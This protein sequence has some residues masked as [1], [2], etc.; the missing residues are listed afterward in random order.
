MTVRRAAA[1]IAFGLLLIVLIA[2]AIRNIEL[3]TGQYLSN[4]VPPLPAL[5]VLLLLSALRPFLRRHAPRLAPNRAQ[6]LLL[7]SMLT[8]SVILSGLYHV[9]AF[10]PQLV[11]LQYTGRENPRYAEY[12]RTLPAWYAPQDAQA[13]KDYFEGAKGGHIPWRVWLGPLSCWSLFFLALFVG[14]FSLVTLVQRQWIHHEKLSFPLLTIPLA[15]TTENPLAEG[16]VRLRRWL[17]AL[18]FGVAALFNGINILHIF[19]PSVPAPGFALSFNGLFPN[20]P[21]TPLEQLRL[22]FM[23]ETIGI[24]Y[25]IPLE[26]SFSAWFFYLVVNR[27]IAIAGTAAGYDLPGFPFMREASA[28]GYVAAGLLLLWGLR[29]HFRL[30]S[31][32]SKIENPWAWAGL[33]GSSLFILGFCRAAGLALPLALAYF[34]VIALFVLVYARIRAET[35]VPFG[36]IYP[37]GLPKEMLLNGLSVP[38]ALQWGGV[39]SFV[40]LNSLNW[41]SYFHHPMEQVAYQLDSAKLAE[42]GRIAR[43]ILFTALLLAFI[44]GL[45]AAFWAHLS[46]CC[47]QGSNLTPS[48]GG[49]GE[50]RAQMAHQSNQQMASRL[51]SPP[52]RDY[53]RLLATT[54]GFGFVV[55][56]TALRQRFVGFPFH[57][58]GFLMATAYGDSATGWFPLLVAWLVKFCLLRYG[59]MRMYRAGMPFFLGLAIGH[60]LVAG[61]LWP[62]ISLFI[63]SEAANAY[64][65]V[66]GE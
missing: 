2:V 14:V 65:L 33:F 47:A 29:R 57:P 11:D 59:G 31:G 63:A 27:G 5:A 50:Y 53:P 54:G 7:Y 6:I 60:F 56:L 39:Q 34:G 44:V 36:F 66:F 3:V 52:P 40:L 45:G 9:R 17:F 62:V 51:A 48:A 38:V 43:R 18:G 25:F 22:Y 64:H 15:L 8:V 21:W 4:G 23:L 41:L 1:A 61:L 10:L 16:S 19:Q 35:G 26:I 46:A 12:A 30:R 20:R 55:L 37:E 58:L 49:I 28:G 13:V 42:E 24:G 32:Q